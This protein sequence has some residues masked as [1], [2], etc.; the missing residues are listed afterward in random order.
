[1]DYLIKCKYVQFLPH[2]ILQREQQKVQTSTLN[3][4]YKRP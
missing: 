2:L 1:M 3:S 4:I